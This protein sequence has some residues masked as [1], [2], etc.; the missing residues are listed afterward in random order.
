[1]ET[2]NKQSEDEKATLKHLHNELKKAQS[3][4]AD[5]EELLAQIKTLTNENLK[6]LVSGEAVTEKN[7]MAIHIQNL[8][9]KN[10]NLQKL[11]QEEELSMLPVG[12]IIDKIAESRKETQKKSKLLHS[13]RFQFSKSLSTKQSNQTRLLYNQQSTT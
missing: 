10:D 8:V 6:K 12:A 1:M 9:K 3:R 13:R 7:R 5:K 4:S 11:V 2:L